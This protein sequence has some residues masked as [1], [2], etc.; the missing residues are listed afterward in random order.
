MFRTFILLLLVLGGSGT[1]FLGILCETALLFW[2]FKLIE[3]GEEQ[4]L[5]DA[6]GGVGNVF[7]MCFVE[8]YA[9]AFENF[10]GEGIPIFYLFGQG[11]GRRVVVQVD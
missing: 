11:V 1:G 10:G 8:V 5:D 9:K 6:R 2:L 7:Y 3:D 4:L